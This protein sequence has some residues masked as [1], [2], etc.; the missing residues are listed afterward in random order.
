MK[1]VALLAVIPALLAAACA[2][3]NLLRAGRPLTRAEIVTL[4]KAS[5][6]GLANRT[7]R[8]SWLSGAHGPDVLMG[9]DGRPKTI[10]FTYGVEAG[11]VSGTVPGTLA[12]P[13]ATSR[14][15][16]VTSVVDY[17]GRRA[18]RC[19]GSFDDGE[20]T[21]EYERR[22]S[23]KTWTATA[24]RRNAPA[25][26]PGIA[27]AFEMLQGTTAIALGD[28]RVI[29]GRE[30]RA[31]IAPLRPA[32]NAFDRAP[33]LRGDP[34]PDVHGDAVPASTMQFL[35]IDTT[36]LLPLRWEV[37]GRSSGPD[38]FQF[39]YESIDVRAPAGIE[40]PGCIR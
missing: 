28:R 11:T 40:P 19:D 22:S 30:A 10:R 14:H 37:T 12:A 20:M 26:P 24:R 36:S 2:P 32:A 1:A 23:T 29:D 25:E 15:D 8:L 34:T 39:I 17:P 35:W 13:P 18:K 5:R 31:L 27:A 16:D 9:P 33:L 38:G 6:E 4:L 3:R 21:I 7:I